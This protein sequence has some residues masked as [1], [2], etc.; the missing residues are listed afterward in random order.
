MTLVRPAPAKIPA[1]FQ[2]DPEVLGF[3]RA[4]L[5][6]VQLQADQI[7]A[8]GVT[9]IA[10]GGTGASSASDARD[11]LGVTIGSDVQAYDA[12][13]D[14]LAALTDADGAFIVGTGSGWATESGATARTSM[15]AAAA[16]DVTT[17]TADIAALETL[18]N[19]LRTYLVGDRLWSG[20]PDLTIDTNFD[21][22]T[23]NG[24]VVSIDG[25]LASVAAATCDT[26]TSATFAAG[27]WAIFLVSSDSSGTLTAAWDDNGNSGYADEATAIAALPAAPADEAP[28]GY[29]TV[30]A[31]ASN[32]FTA[33]TDALQGGTGG[34]PAQATNYYNLADPAGTIGAA[35]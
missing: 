24:V 12:D 5:R 16:S 9:P 32:S 1:A 22:Q 30:Q 20:N 18:A 13:L 6:T 7:G 15:G 21:V 34:N 26:G 10:S 33:G 27:T 31:D 29:V 25:V 11:N 3:F 28:V 35:V 2:R 8:A 4:L 19:S 17:N 23:Q 14:E